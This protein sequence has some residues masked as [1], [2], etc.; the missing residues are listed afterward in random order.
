M[1]YIYKKKKV[2]IYIYI[3]QKK[4]TTM[5]NRARIEPRIYI[6]QV[7]EGEGRGGGEIKKIKK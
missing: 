1:K 3:K 6:E 7:G 5:G 2:Y 4:E